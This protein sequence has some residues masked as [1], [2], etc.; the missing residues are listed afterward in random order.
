MTP[1]NQSKLIQ[2]LLHSLGVTE[3]YTGFSPAVYA[4]QLAL[5]SPYRLRFITKLIYP[6]VAGRYHTSREAVERNMRTL[7][8]AAWKNNPVMLSELA[9]FPL[10]KKP[11]NTQFLS[12]LTY[13]C[14]RIVL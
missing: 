13:F 7:V 11:T 3:N 12:I 14:T 4:V 6:D 2:W 10:Q 1:P 5:E 9:G 8:S